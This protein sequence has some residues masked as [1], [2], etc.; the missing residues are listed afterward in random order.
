MLLERVFDLLGGMAHDPDFCAGFGI[1]G[2][3]LFR[4]IVTLESGHGREGFKLVC[5]SGGGGASVDT[6]EVWHLL[7]V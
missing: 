3:Q 4:S 2:F 6:R 5:G 7:M 1:V